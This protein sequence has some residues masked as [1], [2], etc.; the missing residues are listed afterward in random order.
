MQDIPNSMM[1]SF[2][3]GSQALMM[4]FQYLEQFL[5]LYLDRCYKAIKERMQDTIPFDRD[6]KHVENMSYGK[7][8]GE[9]NIYN[10]N[11]KLLD[12]LGKLREPRNEL[13]H[14]G[15]II[16]FHG[17]MKKEYLEKELKRMKEIQKAVKW[18]IKNIC[19]EF[20]RFGEELHL[21]FKQAFPND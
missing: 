21:A 4:D 5:K 11:T 16:A 2:M 10:D 19:E 15:F 14:A 7:L 12:V 8:L 13:A 9:F 1:D 6:R 17:D 20:K 18:C 3:L